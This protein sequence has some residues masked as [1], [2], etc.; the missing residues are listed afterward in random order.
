ME[1]VVRR[2]RLRFMIGFMLVT[3]CVCS[4]VYA[5]DGHREVLNGAAPVDSDV[6]PDAAQRLINAYPEQHLRYVNQQIVF[7]DG[8]SIPWDDGKNKEFDALLDD[9]DIEDMFSMPYVTSGQPAYLQDA[10]RSRCEPF[11]KKMY[12]QNAEAVKKNLV[13]V[14]WFG[15]KVRFTKINGADKALQSVAEEIARD[16]PEFVPYMKSS[17]T[18]YWRKVRGANRLS[19]HSYGI[20][21]D[22]AVK[23]SNYWRW[24]HPKARETDPIGYKNRIPMQIVEVFE[25][26]GFVWGGR[27]YHYDTMHFEYR[28]EIVGMVK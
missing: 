15:E 11:Y 2:L 24:D 7:M 28:P 9:S 21:I 10:G 25:K 22:I 1:V 18:F 19:S 23:Q 4:T 3:A 20:A 26:H 6:I 5:Q 13:S 17:G 27:W 16:Y 8:T 14:S 12:G